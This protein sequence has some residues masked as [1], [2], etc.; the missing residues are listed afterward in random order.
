[1]NSMRW[2]ALLGLT[3][4][5]GNGGCFGVM[6]VDLKDGLS[7]M[8]EIR[9][10][11]KAPA[12]RSPQPV[13]I[14]V[15]AAPGVGCVFI[16]AAG[17]AAQLG[18]FTCKFFSVGTSDPDDQIK[19]HAKTV[20]KA[21]IGLHLEGFSDSVTTLVGKR[22]D[23]RFTG[24]STRLISGT[25]PAPGELTVVPQ[26]LIAYMGW[27]KLSAKH[28]QVDLTATLPDGRQVV[29]RGRG[30]VDASWGHLGWMIPVGLILF[31]AGMIPVGLSQDSIHLDG[32]Q[33]A[34]LRGLDRAA[35][36]LGAKLA[37]T[38][39][40][41]PRAP[42]PTVAAAPPPL[43]APAPPAPALPAPAP[44][45]ATAGTCRT[46][47]DCSG[48]LVCEAGR[49]VAPSP[50]AAATTPPPA[51]TATAPPPAPPPPAAP[52]PA[53]PPPATPPP[54]AP[55]PVTQPPAS[56]P[57]VAAVT[58]A[59]APAATPKPPPKPPRTAQLQQTAGPAASAAE[60]TIHGSTSRRRHTYWLITSI[61]GA[62]G[63]VGTL[64][65]GVTSTGTGTD[66]S[67][68]HDREAFDSAVTQQQVAYGLSI[69]LGVVSVA[70][71]VL[72]LVT[73]EDVPATATAATTTT[74]NQRL[75]DVAG[76]PGELGL[77]GI[78]RF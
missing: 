16:D 12:V 47:M 21:Q 40:T 46:D 70:A 3:A 27:G 66:A 9:G 74:E 59:P 43:P 32:L 69:G 52:P 56:S 18:A 50:P 7:K 10:E 58:P 28:V 65:W 31:P 13:R 48:E 54:V 51:P 72:Y 61:A 71:L 39:L 75:L 6:E 33:M 45:V 34:A 60:A 73:G 23:E 53:T 30:D 35:H 2:L 15:K 5:L 8:E 77:S 26:V 37:Q 4:A 63:A 38:S 24:A 44:G 22:M 42:T 19:A 14:A 1:M 64:I 49:C 25:G 41:P 29:G 76:G 57:V 68:A 11:L 17:A 36:D 55:A 78:W 62:A 20:P 67:E